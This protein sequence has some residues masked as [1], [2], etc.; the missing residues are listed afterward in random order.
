MLVHLNPYNIK[1]KSK[2][3][4]KYEKIINDIMKLTNEKEHN[5]QI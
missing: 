2:E 5:N 3:K 4:E 1:D